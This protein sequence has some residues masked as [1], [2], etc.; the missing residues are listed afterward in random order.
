MNVYEVISICIL[1]II[2]CGGVV[3]GAMQYMEWREQRRELM[4]L[5]KRWLRK[6]IRGE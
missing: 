1:T 2:A 6:Q 4:A 3:Y 5:Q